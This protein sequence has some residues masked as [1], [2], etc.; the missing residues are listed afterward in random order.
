MINPI[1]FIREARNELGKVVW[2]NRRETIRITLGV[3]L[4]CLVVAVILGSADFGLTKLI[5]W[6]IT[7][8]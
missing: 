6:A 3:V 8:K 5:E 4:I 7:K 2:P 1:Q